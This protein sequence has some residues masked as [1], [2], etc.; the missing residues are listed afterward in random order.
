MESRDNFFNRSFTN[1]PSIIEEDGSIGKRGGE[2]RIVRHD[3]SSLAK[4]AQQ[5]R[6]R[7][8]PR[9]IERSRRLV[10]NEQFGFHRQDTGQRH[11]PFLTAA[12]MVWRLACGCC[13]ADELKRCSCAL[14]GFCLGHSK[15]HGPKGDVFE[16]SGQEQLFI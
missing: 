11:A 14:H 7:P 16:Y 10:E 4:A 13:H 5:V 9:R 2:F 15:I 8:L 6:E 3:D 1:D 12:Q